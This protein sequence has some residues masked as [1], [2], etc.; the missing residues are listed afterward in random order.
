[1]NGIVMLFV[2]LNIFIEPDPLWDN[3]GPRFSL[4]LQDKDPHFLL[5]QNSLSLIWR[6]LS[7]SST[8]IRHKGIILLQKV[9][10]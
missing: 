6:L 4:A 7:Q 8:S 1:V 2:L 10:E 5:L 9:Q 3:P